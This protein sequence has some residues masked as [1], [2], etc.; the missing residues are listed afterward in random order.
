[1]SVRPT[2]V[3][4]REPDDIVP[5]LPDELRLFARLEGLVG[6]EHALLSI[7]AHERTSEQHDLLRAI[8]A[9]L[10]RLWAYLQER[11]ERL[12]RRDQPSESQS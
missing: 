7:P 3:T 9:E 11:A 6:Q 1:M 12:A 4:G 8:T 5:S 2:F 10:D